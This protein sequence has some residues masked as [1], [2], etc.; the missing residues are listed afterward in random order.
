MLSFLQL[1]NENDNKM[2]K[3]NQ[4]TH[5]VLH[6]TIFSIYMCQE[7]GIYTNKTAERRNTRSDRT[8]WETNSGEEGKRERERERER[9]RKGRETQQEG[10]KKDK[11][12]E[13]ERER[14]REREKE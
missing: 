8:R 2:K 12:R 13:N 3:L 1:L 4:P 5:I 9:E 14:E 7:L 6:Q 10:M 11:E